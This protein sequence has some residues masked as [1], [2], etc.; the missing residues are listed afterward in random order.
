MSDSERS[1]SQRTSP[2]SSLRSGPRRNDQYQHPSSIRTDGRRRGEFLFSL[3]DVGG[4]KNSFLGNDSGRNQFNYSRYSART[5]PTH[6]PN[7]P[8]ETPLP[9]EISV[10]SKQSNEN[11]PPMTSS[12]IDEYEFVD[13]ST[14]S[15][16]FDNSQKKISIPPSSSKRR[17]PSAISQMPVSMHPTVQFSTEPI[18]I[19]FGDIQWNDSVPTAVSPSSDH[20]EEISSIG[21]TENHE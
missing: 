9:S 16:T 17:I 21:N 20:E 12:L 6:K 14:Q 3:I 10:P 1:L 7:P 13:G 15:L 18:D 11:I 5:N 4:V 2:A 19:Q 8:L